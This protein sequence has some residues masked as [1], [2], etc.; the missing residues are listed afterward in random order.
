MPF[1]KGFSHPLPEPQAREFPYWWSVEAHITVSGE[2]RYTAKKKGFSGTYSFKASVYGSLSDDTEDYAFVQVLQELNSIDWKEIV[3]S[4]SGQEEYS[5]SNKIKPEITINYVFQDGRNLSF[6]FEITRVPAPYPCT[7]FKSPVK[8][9]TMPVCSGEKQTRI[10]YDYNKGIAS[11]S[12]EVRVNEEDI[13]SSA[14]TSRDYEWSWKE[15]LP[16][17]KWGSHHTVHLT[18]KLTRMIK[19]HLREKA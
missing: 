18:L 2:Y 12:N 17:P 9:I 10:R 13:C 19:K 8:H 5:L 15:V 7:V 4:K 16:D 14:E 3:T 6:D 11:G 1:L